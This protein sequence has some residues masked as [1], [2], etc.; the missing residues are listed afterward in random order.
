MQEKRAAYNYNNSRCAC[1][2]LKTERIPP[3]FINLTIAFVVVNLKVQIVLPYTFLCSLYNCFFPQVKQSII[4]IS[5][6][7]DLTINEPHSPSN[8]PHPTRF[9]NWFDQYPTYPPLILH[10]SLPLPLHFIRYNIII[11]YIRLLLL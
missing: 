8:P 7:F 3:L 6:K 4:I 9:G 2:P 11:Q 10:S 5:V 1:D